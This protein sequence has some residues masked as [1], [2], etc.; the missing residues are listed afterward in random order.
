MFISVE[1]LIYSYMALCVCILLYNIIFII[2]KK[3]DEK[4]S[5]NKVNK[6]KSAIKMQFNKNN[7]INDLD[8]EYMLQKRLLRISQLYAYD[9]ALQTL[10]KS[11]Y[12]ETKEYLVNN[13]NIFVYLA[14]KYHDKE[15]TKKAF[16]VYTLSKYLIY[17]TAS[18]DRIGEIIIN[19][20]LDKSIYCRENALKA[21]YAIGNAEYVLTAYKLMNKNLIFHNNKL[22]ADGLLLFNGDKNNLCNV[23]WCSFNKFH[24]N[25]QIAII[26]FIKNVSGDYC[27]Q[28]YNIL[29]RND[30]NQEIKFA[31]IRYYRKYYYEPVKDYLYHCIKFQKDLNPT[32]SALAASALENYPSDETILILKSALRS[33]NWY[34]R[35]NASNSLRKLGIKEGDLLDIFS[36]DDRYAK[37]M[38][39]YKLL[40]HN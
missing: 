35:N 34:T 12:E 18:N 16:F 22:V 25:Y 4:L 21:I 32:F 15:S 20:V 13:M 14:K 17:D 23:L 7:A 31:I 37:E 3:I 8:H 30:T 26:N 40:I 2:Y 11:N 28:F 10:L 29:Q 33:S 6:W 19:Y 38:M 24:I 1:I 27:E 5:L 36:G 9:E 39:E